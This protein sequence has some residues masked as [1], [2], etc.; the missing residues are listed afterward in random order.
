MR[1]TNV[2][3]V[4]TYMG[5]ANTPNFL[6][7]QVGDVA[8]ADATNVKITFTHEEFD[9]D[10]AVAT[11]TFTCPSGADGKYWFYSH[12]YMSASVD[13]A[14]ISAYLY[15]NGGIISRTVSRSSGTSGDSCW[16]A[17]ILDLSATDTVEVY[18]RQS[19]GSSQNVYG[20]ASERFTVFAGFKL[21]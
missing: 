8:V 4:K 7:Y 15:K 21:A 18:A 1:M 19:T 16:V 17:G 9:S 10:S 13:G 12:M 5:G 11:S 6:L 20:E 3:T 2:T 14:Y